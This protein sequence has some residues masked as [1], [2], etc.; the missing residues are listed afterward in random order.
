MDRTDCAYLIN[1][2]PK[3]FY[4]LPLHI[5]LLE[6]YATI[7]WPIYIATEAPELLP[8]LPPHVKILRLPMEAEGFLDSRAEATK[9]LPPEIKYVFPMQEDFLL[10][11]RPM[12]QEIYAAFEALEEVD[13]VRLMPCP[14]PKGPVFYNEFKVLDFAIEMVFTYQATL[15]KREAYGTFMN[16]LLHRLKGK[17]Q[18]E[19]NRIGIKINI[20]ENSDGQ[21][22]LR[23]LGGIHLS[24]IRQYPHPNAVYL[25]P[26][27]YRPTAVVQGVLQPWAIDLGEREGFQLNR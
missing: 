7:A 9:L 23:E 20:A 18:A 22:I 17:S 26:W 12:A 27:P 14:G 3:Y 2:T 19:K 10:E 4:L 5:A 15:W 6:R 16:T 24:V 8:S 25:C 1:T 13:S 21:A 11:G